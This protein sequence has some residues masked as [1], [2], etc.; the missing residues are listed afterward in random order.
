MRKFALIITAIFL[1]AAISLPVFAANDVERAGLIASVD[2]SGSCQVTLTLTLRM[3]QMDRTMRYPI[4]ADATNILLNG[5]PVGTYQAGAVQQVDLSGVINPDMQKLTCSL[6]YTLPNVLSDDQVQ[7][8]LL[9]GF[10]LPVSGLDFT[11]RMPT[12]LTGKP[13][14]TSTYHQSNIEKDLFWNYAGDTI[15]GRSINQIKD[16]ETLILYVPVNSNAFT[17]ATG[18]I[19][20]TDVDEIGLWI[21]IGLALIYWI[22]F[23]RTGLPSFQRF[24]QPPQGYTAGNLSSVLTLEGAD[25]SLMVLSWAQMG[26]VILERERSGK[27]LIH[28][29]MGMGNERSEFEQRIFNRLFSKRPTVDTSS[30]QYALLSKNVADQ[31]GLS[32]I[33]AHK[34]SGNPRIFRILTSLS[35]MFAGMYAGLCL[36]LTGFWQ[37]FVAIIY[38]IAGFLCAW[39]IQLGAQGILLWRPHRIRICITCLAVWLILCLIPGAFWFGVL[40]AALL[41]LF[42][43]LGTYGGRR[44][45]EGKR[46]V[47]QVMGLRK[48]L[49]TISRDSVSHILL[50]DADFFHN[51]APYALALGVDLAF[52][53]NFGKTPIAPCP[54]LVGIPTGDRTAQEYA[55]LLRDIFSSMDARYHQL[56]REQVGK[57]IGS[58]RK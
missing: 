26:Y 32:R 52:A 44:T 47:N 54:Y 38:C 34:N 29:A 11:V 40:I 20:N 46:N 37:G 49:R 6:Q 25:L 5:S 16:Y 22:I 2:S 55:Q 48:H 45:E 24:T 7:I 17:R 36:P 18:S 30:L 23:L 51:M 14:F 8:P 10:Q 13:S 27:V 28:Y 43:I 12:E 50:Q 41:L 35:G 21:C 1:I 39:G 15:T 58:I 33:M 56:S 31:A 42:G 3:D 19:F 57:A 9:S 53:N 4:P